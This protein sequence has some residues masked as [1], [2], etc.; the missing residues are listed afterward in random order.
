MGIAILLHVLA[1]VV[2]VGGM[3]FAYMALRPIA[4]SVLE[5]PERLTLWAGVFGKFFFW[6]IKSIV[7]L[8]ATGFWIIFSVMDGFAGAGTHVHLMLT[9]GIIMILMFFHMFFGPYKRLKAAV[10]G[11]DWA[12][13]GKQL[14]Q[15]RRLVGINLLLGL[16]TVAV[17]SG[18]RFLL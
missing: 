10:A 4:A 7:V 1:A 14:A 6:V 3:F 5:P 12:T 2:W 13:G 18:G 17:A 9:L 11:E 16:L 8:L 15:I